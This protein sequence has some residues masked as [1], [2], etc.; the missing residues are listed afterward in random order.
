MIES[1]DQRRS[2]RTFGAAQTQGPEQQ[3]AEV[4]RVGRSQSLLV[5][6]VGLGDDLVH[7][8]GHR[9]VGRSDPLILSAI[10]D[11]NHQA[12]GERLVGYVQVAEHARHQAAL[13]IRVVDHEVLAN[14]HRLPVQAQEPRR[15]AMEGAQPHPRQVAALAAEQARH[16]IFH[17]ARSLVGEGHGQNAMRV[18][19]LSQE[20]GQPACDHAGLARARAGDHQ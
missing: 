5:A 14:A 10:D 15:Q 16:T 11:G 13:I 3:A 1:L 4:H 20:A 17:L 18:G 8:T 7:G 2:R 6:T 19:S 12:H 9:K